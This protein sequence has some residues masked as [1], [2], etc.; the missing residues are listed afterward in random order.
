MN[1]ERITTRKNFLKWSGLAVFGGAFLVGK[2]VS[3]SE[4]SLTENEAKASGSLA[5]VPQVRPAQGVVVRE[6]V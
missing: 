1:G 5:K 3:C 4:E 6:R 2:Q